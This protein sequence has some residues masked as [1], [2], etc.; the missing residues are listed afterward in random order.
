MNKIS[1]ELLKIANQF[2]SHSLT[3]NV[4]GNLSYIIVPWGQEGMDAEQLVTYI[5]R[6]EKQLKRGFDQL[7]GYVEGCKC[8]GIKCHNGQLFAYCNIST[9]Q[10]A[11]AFM[12]DV[13]PESVDN[14]QVKSY[15]QDIL[16]ECF[17]NISIKIQDS[18]IGEIVSWAKKILNKK[19]SI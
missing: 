10:I 17:P 13:K 14:V 3:L 11:K 6:T 12:E 18:Q 8:Q 1:K 15:I 16:K 2:N 9:Y 4:Y 7:N 19:Q 5:L